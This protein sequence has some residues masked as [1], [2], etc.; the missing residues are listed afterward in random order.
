MGNKKVGAPV[1][2]IVVQQIPEQ[3]PKIETMNATNETKMRVPPVP[4]F[5]GPGRDRLRYQRTGVFHFFTFSYYCAG[6]ICRLARPWI[7]ARLLDI[8]GPQERGTGGTLNRVESFQDQGHP[9]E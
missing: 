9:P 2:V 3:V 8:P 6:P 7:S 1:A 5:W 4:C